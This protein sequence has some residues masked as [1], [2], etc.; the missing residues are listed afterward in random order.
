MHMNLVSTAVGTDLKDSDLGP[1]I[2]NK[3]ETLKTD[4]A[5]NFQKKA[6]AT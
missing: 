4:K 6:F 2:L 5:N 3:E 1:R